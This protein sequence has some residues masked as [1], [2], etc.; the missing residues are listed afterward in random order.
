MAA[1]CSAEPDFDARVK[2]F[3]ISRAVVADLVDSDICFI[4][5]QLDEFVYVL[6]AEEAVK[7]GA[8]EGPFFFPEARPAALKYRSRL[9]FRTNT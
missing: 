3:E 7:R 1:F 8:R 4:Q 5:E 6:D 2:T 9:I